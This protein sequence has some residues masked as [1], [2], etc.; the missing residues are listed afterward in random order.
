[1]RIMRKKIAVK[2]TKKEDAEFI[3]VAGEKIKCR[4]ENIDIHTLEYYSEN[5]RVASILSSHPGETTQEFIQTELWKLDTTKDL[6]WDIKRNKGLLEE[7]IVKGNQVLEGNSRLC[8]YR[9]LCDRATS[10]EE[11]RHWSYIRARVLPSNI[12]SEQIFILLGTFHIRGKA[13]W[14][15]YEQ[16]SYLHKMIDV[17]DRT[18]KEIGEMIGI[19]EGAVNNM[20]DSYRALNYGGIKDLEKF[21]FFMEYYKNRDLRHL[22]KENPRLT[23]D[24][25]EWVKEDRIP[26]AEW[27]RDLP[28]ILKDKKARKRFADGE[29]FEEARAIAHKRHPEAV[30]TFY[31]VLKKTTE[32]LKE[33]PPQKVTE[34]INSD[35]KKRAIIKYL[36]R[37]IKRFCR[38]VGIEY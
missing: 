27:V 15:T 17:F 5:P 13:K 23:S 12:T 25:T 20:I 22:R 19:K 28:D 18:P 38:N 34:E 31:G 24:F 33:A 26:R 35:N 7:V 10:P 16:A 30:D 2:K 32:I 21:S 9:Y 36:A 14:R 3:T 37:E 8:A 1:M 4:L 6:F 29:D 11:K